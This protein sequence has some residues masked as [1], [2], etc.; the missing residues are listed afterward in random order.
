MRQ[1]QSPFKQMRPVPLGFS[2]MGQNAPFKGENTM[3]TQEQIINIASL[4][5][6]AFRFK[7]TVDSLLDF[8]AW[9]RE[10]WTAKAIADHRN[11]YELD[12]RSQEGKLRFAW[13]AAKEL[14]Q[15]C[16][17]LPKEDKEIKTVKVLSQAIAFL[18]P[19]P[20]TNGLENS[21]AYQIM[22]KPIYFDELVRNYRVLAQKYHPDNNPSVEAVGRFQIVNEIYQALKSQW[23]DKYSPLIPI[24]RI[25]RENIER[26]Y[27][28][29]FPFDP[30]SFWG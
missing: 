8:Y 13:Y 28:K 17:P 22:G 11:K 30:D 24:E 12:C 20:P 14:S 29:Q 10:Q 7:N 23:F 2:L 16:L 4:P 27:S 25:G 26:A 18:K 6:T 9:V 19:V 15:N 21:P 1:G 3:F 5:E